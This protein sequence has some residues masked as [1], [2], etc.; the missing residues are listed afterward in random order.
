MHR[1]SLTTLFAIAA[2]IGAIDGTTPAQKP[3]AVQSKSQARPADRTEQTGVQ[4]AA[5]AQASPTTYPSLA[6]RSKKA[7]I[8]TGISEPYFNKHFRLLRVV[9]EMDERR[10]E[11]K[12][13]INEYETLLVD[14][15]GY[16]TSEKGERVDVHSIKNELFSTYDIKRTI[17]K[18]RADA[19]LSSCIGEHT[20]ASVVYRARKTPG[21][22]RLYLMA[23]SR[24]EVEREDE[25]DGKRDKEGEREIEGFFFN[26]GFVDL[27]SGKCAIERGKVTP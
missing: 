6:A 3:D 18:S 21:K 14:D 23:R 4:A 13:S 1:K 15:V 19:A 16:Y 25:K 11:W 8:E 2:L 27:E 12:Y 17:P 26:V 22:A 7:I 24:V 9:A 5:D 20:D 10:V